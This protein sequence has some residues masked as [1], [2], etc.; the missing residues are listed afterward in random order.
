MDGY[1]IA[2]WQVRLNRGSGRTGTGFAHQ[3]ENPQLRLEFP[4]VRPC[5]DLRALSLVRWIVRQLV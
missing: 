2:A 3:P 1:G 5:K 4:Y